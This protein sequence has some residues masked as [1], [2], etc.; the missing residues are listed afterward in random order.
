MEQRIAVVT[1]STRGLGQAI[2]AGLAAAGY[3]T[4]ITGRDVAA[5]ERVA[6]DLQARFVPLD[7]EQPDSIERFAAWFAGQYGGLDVLVNNAGMSLSGFNAEVARRTL[8]VNYG[9]TWRLTDALR[10][11]L[12]PGARVVMVSSGMGELSCLSRELQA[13]F[14]APDLTRAGLQA[15]CDRFIADVAAR[16]QRAQGWPSNAYAVSKV[17]MNA[18]VR[19][20]AAELAADPAVPDCTVN[21]VCP[22]WVRTAMGGPGAP[23]SPEEGARTPLW[24]AMHPPGGPNGA[25]FRS[26]RQIPW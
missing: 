13:E 21:A 14:L 8:A 12:R 25:F 24:L 9:G 26:Q 10:P 1:G 15:L 20:L 23:L 4:V 6:A 19:L 2:A 22:G 16:R 11:R 5:G 3:T 18:Y 7:V 17:A